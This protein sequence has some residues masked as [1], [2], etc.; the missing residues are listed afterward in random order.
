M[1]QPLH[2]SIPSPCS[3]DWSKMT[4]QDQGRFCK[5]CQ[6]CVIDFTSWTDKQLYEYV[7][8]NL[9]KKICG[10]FDVSQLNRPIYLPP[11]PHSHLYHYFIGL[12]LTLLTATVPVEQSF[13]KAPYNYTIPF[14]AN[15]ANPNSSDSITIK[16]RVVDE[17]GEPMIGA[18]V[19]LTQGGLSKGGAQTDEEG[20]YII[21]L[22]DTGTFSITAIYPA[23]I[24]NQI[25][26]I[27]ITS[28]TTTTIDI[29][30]ELDKTRKDLRETRVIVGN[31][32]PFFNDKNSTVIRSEDIEHMAR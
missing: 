3:E 11:Q 20:L 9:N 21:P 12:G 24:I 5:S 7:Q 31:F 2:I 19:K 30:M 27:T 13:A 16:G 1:K 32:N 4:P 8:N 14:N 26:E 23:Y 10:R 17:K 28:N 29:K 22:K 6:K 15:E 25:N 18:I